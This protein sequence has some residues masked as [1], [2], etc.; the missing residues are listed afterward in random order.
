MLAYDVP[1]EQWALGMSRLFLKA[2]QMKALEDMRYS[3]VSPD[4]DKLATIVS[5]IIRKKW[6]RAVN[7]VKLCLYVPKLI[8]QIQVERSSKVLSQA[9]PPPHGP[10]SRAARQAGILGIRASRQRAQASSQR[11]EDG[12]QPGSTS[13]ETLFVVQACA[14]NIEILPRSPK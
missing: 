1:R 3:G 9:L 11:L 10:G 5:G 8:T 7:A 4:P 6:T 14:G 2:G 13:S 12:S